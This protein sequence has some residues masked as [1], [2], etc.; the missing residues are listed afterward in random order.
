MLWA[1]YDVDHNVGGSTYVELTDSGDAIG[2]NYITIDK[3]MVDD[4]YAPYNMQLGGE[5]VVAM[6]EAGHSIGVARLQWFFGWYEV[7]DSDYSIMSVMRTE[8]AGFT[9]HW[10]YSWNHWNTRNLVYY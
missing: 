8:N 10:Y 3:G 9:N 6:H 4:Y 5:V 1:D 7:Y 2:G